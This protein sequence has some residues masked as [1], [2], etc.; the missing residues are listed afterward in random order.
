MPAEMDATQEKM[1]ETLERQ[2]GSPVSIMG[3]ARKT[4]RDEIKQAI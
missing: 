1:Q 3:A 4:G 2:I